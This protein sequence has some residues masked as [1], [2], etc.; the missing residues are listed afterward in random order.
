M[1]EIEDLAAIHCD[2]CGEV[3]GKDLR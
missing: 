1:R 2:V 3:I